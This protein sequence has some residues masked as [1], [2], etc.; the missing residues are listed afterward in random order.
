MDCKWKERNQGFK[1]GQKVKKVILSIVCLGLFR[2]LFAEEVKMQPVPDKP[3]VE[4]SVVELHITQ[5]AFDTTAEKRRRKKIQ[6][7]AGHSVC[8]GVFLD[9]MGDILTAG[10]CA[11]G[12]SAIEVETYN[13]QVYQAVIVATSSI[14]D[15]ALLH[16]DKLNTP[17]MH[18]ASSVTRGEPI[19]I[20]GSPLAIND[21]LSTGI[22]AKLI[23]DVVLVDCSVLPGNSGS[24]V[25]NT[26]RELVGI[27]TAGFI[28]G[29]GVTHLNII[30]SLDAV[31]FFVTE[32]LQRR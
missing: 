9:N 10:H 31:W 22:V 17:F 20:L 25:F 19:F 12:V 13:R 7:M 23:G 4:Q 16:I 21:T 29:L 1:R 8:S 32:T 18:L 27:A 11:Q 2:G 26:N 3:A 5:L 15:L 14:H 30:Q 24:P 6:E 28:V